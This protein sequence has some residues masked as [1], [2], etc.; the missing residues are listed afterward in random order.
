MHCYVGQ[1]E[2]TVVV[3]YDLA[4]PWRHETEDGEGDVKVCPDAT[5]FFEVLTL[6]FQHMVR[7]GLSV[8]AYRSETQMNNEA[9][10]GQTCGLTTGRLGSSAREIH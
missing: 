2:G 6:I 7:N 5:L 10:K 3:T 8:Q 9:N 1:F 4:G